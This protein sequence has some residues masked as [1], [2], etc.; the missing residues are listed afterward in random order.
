MIL[1][2]MT[3]TINDSRSLVM[4]SLEGRQLLTRWVLVGFTF[5]GPSPWLPPM[6]SG[7]PRPSRPVDSSERPILSVEV[8]EDGVVA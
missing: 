6:L 8:E 3:V 4:V 2:R 1:H 5:S 7:P